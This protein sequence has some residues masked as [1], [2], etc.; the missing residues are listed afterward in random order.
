MAP[1]ADAPSCRLCSAVCS[2]D[3]K[4]ATA[5]VT[6]LGG[7]GGSE[8][9][10]ALARNKGELRHLLGKE[11]TAKYVP[12]LR[13]RLDETYD[14]MDDTRRLFADETVQRDIAARD[15]GDF[16][17]AHVE[18]AVLGDAGVDR[19][20]GSIE[21]EFAEFEK[22]EFKSKTV[23]YLSDEVDLIDTEKESLKAILEKTSDDLIIAFDKINFLYM[24]WDIS[25]DNARAQNF[26]PSRILNSRMVGEISSQLSAT[27][28]ST[29]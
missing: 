1:R 11:M 4:V 20:D 6:P 13:F 17:V 9:I 10:A 18:A 21:A 14:Q 24:A 8:L 16:V 15:E 19:L 7:K 22:V 29:R 26:T 3:L 12:D 27:A 23:L 2:P 25:L 5:Y 28:G